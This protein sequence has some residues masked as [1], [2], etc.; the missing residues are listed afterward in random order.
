MKLLFAGTPEFGREILEALLAS[1][2]EVVMV[3]TQPSRPK[4]RGQ[5]EQPSPVEQA[6]IEKNIP[7]I[8]ASPSKVEV[9]EEIKKAAPDAAV[10]AAY[11]R[12]F[13]P[14]FLNL[15]PKGVL[16]VHPSLLPRWRGA[17]PVH[18]ALLAG[19]KE[20]GV[21][22]MRLVEEMDAGPIYAIEN[23]A[24]EDI[25]DR[26]SL[27]NKL[28]AIGGQLLLDVLDIVS[29]G[30]DQPQEQD[31][32]AATFTPKMHDEDA[33]IQ[34]NDSATQCLNRVR[35]FAPDP[36]AWFNLK[37]KDGKNERIKILA[38]Q[39]RNLENEREV[40]TGTVLFGSSKSSLCVACD[41]S[42]ALELLTVRPQG[43]K[44]QPAASLIHGKKISIGD[45]LP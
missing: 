30:L 40:K 8:T 20:T 10:V 12:I 39:V 1:K 42:T 35:A 5:K 7:V 25:D 29:Q 43:K 38:A 16:N 4:G 31:H 45:V 17:A 36:G 15:P 24:I 3:L 34:W 2:H 11:G 26:L 41:S 32:K 23:L 37:N 21:A 27:E 44:D 33:Q 22:I 13:R 28:A 9:L 6:A 19:D 18:A 14:A